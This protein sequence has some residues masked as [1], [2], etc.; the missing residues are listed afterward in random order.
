[1]AFRPRR[2]ELGQAGSLMSK[3]DM[4]RFTQP[5]YGKWLAIVIMM[6]FALL[7]TAIFAWL[8]NQ[9]TALLV[10]SGIRSGNMALT[11]LLFQFAVLGSIFTLIGIP[12]GT[13]ITLAWA[14]LWVSAFRAWFHGVKHDVKQ[15]GAQGG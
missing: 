4:T 14:V 9:M 8:R 13:A 6:L 10:L 12:A 1:M 11:I 3:F 2:P 7:C 5:A 15:V